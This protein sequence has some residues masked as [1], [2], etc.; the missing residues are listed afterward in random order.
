MEI[1][2]MRGT[3]R[4]NKINSSNIPVTQLNMNDENMAFFNEQVKRCEKYHIIQR[5]PKGYISKST[6][7]PAYDVRMTSSCVELMVIDSSGIF[8]LQ[9]RNSGIKEKQTIYGHKAFLIFKDICKKHNICLDDYI[10]DNGSEVKKEIEGYIIDVENQVFLDRTFKN[11]HH[12]DFHS[13]FPSGLALTHPEF[14]PV[15]EELYNG[16]KE[17]PEY[18]L[19]LNCTIGY[20]QSEPCCKAKWAQLARDAINNNNARIRDLAERL[21]KSGRLVLAYNTDGIWYV[22]DE[23]HDIDEGTT[24]GTWAN[25]H[26]NCKIRFKS[27]GAYEF[28]ENGKYYPVVRGHT[29]LDTI[30]SRD[31]WVWGDIYSYDAAPIKY[32][33]VDNYIKHAEE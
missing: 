8:R 21:K 12:I 17:K 5:T 19:V 4:I 9:F 31:K 23:F 29:K 20:M 15:I 3:R 13:S 14:R 10:I 18:K 24:I 16:R 7:L 25:D 30:K 11:A 1:K 26:T 32:M 6:Q 2:K 22:G 28:E 33:L 27:A